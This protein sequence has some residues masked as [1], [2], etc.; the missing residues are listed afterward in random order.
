MVALVPALL[1]P[2]MAVTATIARLT[3]SPASVAAGDTVAVAGSGFP[4]NTTGTISLDGAQTG[5]TYRADVRGTFTV[6]LGVPAGV[7]VG[8]HTV[9]ATTMAARR[10]RK[11]SKSVAVVIASVSLTVVVASPT[12]NPIPTSSLT[13][14]PSP[15]P[16]A[17]PA[18]TATA[19]P[20][21]TTAAPPSA[22]ASASPTP[23]SASATPLVSYQP[24]LPLRAAFYYPWF[25]EAWTQK[26]IYPFTHY[27]PSLGYYDG[28]SLAVERAHIAAMQY[29][30]IQAGIASWWGQGTM[31]DGRVR[32]ILSAA[33]GT[34]FRWSLY[35][36]AESLGDPSVTQINADLAYI[37]GRYAADPS[38]LRIDGRFVIFVYADGSD[39]CATAQRWH[40]ANTVG[41]YVVLKVFNGY[42]TCASQPD[43]WH[44][45]A[46]AVAADS[47]SGHSY[48]ISPG[49]F[50]ATDS[51][52]RL[53]RDLTAW[54][55]SVR[56]MVASGAP[57]QL[58]TTFNEWGEGTSVESATE[59]PSGSGYG[60]YLDALHTNG[61]MASAP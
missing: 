19:T 38:Y 45:Y 26:E 43:G 41:A 55:A 59:W 54:N 17:T 36:E 9:T 60:A 42:R 22:S 6:T 20:A 27:H 16:T 11:S 4:K 32:A 15:T 37:R 29:G 57:F 1:V 47:Q 44:Q 56:A 21:P 33:A 12:V 24:S 25:P 46:P 48:A 51:A 53:V 23:A 50:L 52:P 49:F 13:A 28:G 30:K 10:S 3:A 34:T 31:T 5:L 8:S 2:M 61:L 14:T 40:D 35:Y 39:G 18:A 7:A 58:V